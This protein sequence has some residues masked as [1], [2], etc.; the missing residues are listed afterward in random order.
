[1]QGM[2]RREGDEGDVYGRECGVRGMRGGCEGD[3]SG[4]RGELIVR[5]L[6]A[7]AGSC[8]GSKVLQ[9]QK[10]SIWRLGG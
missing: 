6:S 8:A 2:E 5:S 4:M 9:V 10:S 7:M 1:M 3:A